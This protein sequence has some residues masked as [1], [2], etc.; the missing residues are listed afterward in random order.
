MKTKEEI[1][2]LAFL[3][4]P[5]LINDPYNPMEDDNTYERQIWI[6]GYTQCQEDM[7]P[8]HTELFKLCQE[9][10]ES[11]QLFINTINTDNEPNIINDIIDWND[12]EGELMDWAHEL[13]KEQKYTPFPSQ[14]LEWLKNNYKLPIKK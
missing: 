13:G 1:E 10:K 4:Y 11:N 6:E 5:R 7:K 8:L 9:L 3:K 2:Q 14:V 12:F